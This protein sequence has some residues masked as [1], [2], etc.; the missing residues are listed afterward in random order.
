MIPNPYE[1]ARFVEEY[2]LFHYGQPAEI[3]PWEFGP[4]DALDFPVRCVTELLEVKKLP[5]G[6]R[7]LDVGCAVGR[8][9]FE[10]ARHCVRVT[11]VDFS[12]ALIEAAQSMQREGR[13]R[14]GYAVEG[15]LR[16]EC[17]LTAPEG[18][19]RTRVVF[20]Q[21]DAMALPEEM[22]D[23]DVVLAANLICRLARP[24]CF[25]KRLPGLVKSGGQLLLCT[26]WTWLEEFTPEEEW[27]GTRSAEDVESF[28]A[29]RAVLE[30]DFELVREKD[31]PFLIREHRR[32]YQWGVSHGSAWRRK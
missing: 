28:A 5:E 23:F 24:E 21:A 11:G 2:L 10:L 26:P 16:K 25:L 3:L 1:S 14:S 9:S 32:K 27:L 17:V 15:K 7:A 19:D 6:A 20:R 22:A 4:R 29:L 8:S 13:V 18:V 31:L 30:P 12:Q